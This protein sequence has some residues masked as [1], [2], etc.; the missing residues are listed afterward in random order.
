MLSD[1]KIRRYLVTALSLALCL[2]LLVPVAEAGKKKKKKKKKQDPAP[3]TQV[4]EAPKAKSGP[5]KAV[6]E[7]FD[8]LRA[9]DTDAAREALD[10]V[11]SDD[12]YAMTARALV[13]EQA[14]DYST[15]TA[16]LRQAAD[17]W[18]DDPA[19]VFYLGETHIH[20]RNMSAADDAFAQAETRARALL[21]KR[22]DDV[23]ALYYLGAAQQR[24]R[25]FDD[26]V[27]TLEKARKA[28]PKNAMVVYQLGATKAFQEK[29]QDAH[30]LLSE[31]IEMDSGIAYAYYYRGLAAGKMG[32][33]DLLINDLDRFLAMA[34]SA[35]EAD[36]A[37]KVR[38]A[39]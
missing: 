6:Q 10:A 38:G 3:T 16:Q 2:L 14:K 20:A 36:N 17:R 19:P 23:E 11:S 26:A 34:P 27:S 13:L 24:Q 21:E 31:T 5:S 32:R 28:D 29:W 8:L 15:A 9:Y 22:P 1:T 25:R 33:K 18:T 12:V 37:K 39:A 7:A 4:E 30:D 35:P